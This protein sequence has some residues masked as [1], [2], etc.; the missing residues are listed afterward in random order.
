M[1]LSKWVIF[2]FHVNLPGVS[3]FEKKTSPTAVPK[4]KALAHW[5]ESMIR[6]SYVVDGRN[7]AITTWDV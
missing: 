4:K 2:R 1:F 3:S 7:P 6:M 5:F